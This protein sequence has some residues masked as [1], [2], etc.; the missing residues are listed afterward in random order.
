MGT[1]WPGWVSVGV[2]LGAA[3][4]AARLPEPAA[5]T[6][7]DDEEELGYL[8]TL[9]AGLAEAAARPGVRGALL[10]AALLGSFDALEEY[11]PLILGG[12]GVPDGADPG[13]GPADRARGRGRR[14]RWRD[15]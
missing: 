6:T 15:G 12:W 4:A 1:R 14:G 5:A 9:R 7:S 3:T 8:A 10:A 13:G 11:F 2:C